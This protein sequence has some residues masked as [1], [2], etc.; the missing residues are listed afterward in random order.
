MPQTQ[1]VFTKCLIA[2]NAGHVVLSTKNQLCGPER[3]KIVLPSI[4]SLTCKME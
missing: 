3:A 2:V 1:L 4:I